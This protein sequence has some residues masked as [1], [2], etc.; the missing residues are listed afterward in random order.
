MYLLIRRHLVLAS[1]FGVISN[2]LVLTP[3]IYLL[4]VYD[5]V[6]PSRSIETLLMLMAFMA[7][8]L[9]MMLLV[10]VVR[11]RILADLGLQLCARLDRLALLARLDASAR[12]R[13]SSTVATQTDI[14]TLRGFL[15][16]PGVVAF[17]DAPWLVIYLII[18]CLFHWV[19]CLIAAISGIVLFALALL[20]DRVI[21]KNIGT[22]TDKQRECDLAYSQIV[23]NAEV[24][25]VLGMAEKIVC[26]WDIRKREYIEAQ[27]QVADSS[28]FY[29][30][31]T[32]VSRQAI[33]VIM[34]A[35]GAWLVIN[36]HATP[37]VM[38]ATTILLGKALA[39]IEQMIGSWKQFGE[40]R[41]AWGRLNEL[42][43]PSSEHDTIALPAPAGALCIERVTF[44]VPS[45][46]PGQAGRLLLR[47]VQF[48]LGAGETLVI[49]G[50]SAS[51][52]STLL[53][54]IAGLWRPQVGAVRLDGADVSQWP[55][56]RL[57]QYLGYVPQDVELFAGTVAENIGRTARPLQLDSDSI[58]RAAKRAGAHEMI[59]GLPN[60]YDTQIGESGETLSGG[61]RQ[62]ISLARAL[63]G[64]PKLLLLD[65]PNANLDSDGEETLDAA[66]RQIR[67]DGVTVIAVT[68]RPALM[69]IADRVLMMRSGQV[70]R[71]GTRNEFA[72]KTSQ[73]T[74]DEIGVPP[75]PA[76]RS[77]S[78]A[79]AMSKA[80]DPAVR[81]LL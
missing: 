79:P 76:I 81:T 69:A 57:G 71:F 7:I 61:Q 12:Q 6:L 31:V 37:G 38:L 22:Y 43:K 63:Y 47:D 13:Q 62:R 74:A 32:K 4:Q 9:A 29:R 27:Q 52:K 35:A 25:T 67:A 1:G 8:T 73:N 56:D 80:L 78:I 33:Q 66:L 55:R 60:G 58:V 64:D 34:M 51:G 23:R 70:E 59:L 49:V 40:L 44:S 72:T 19:L 15:S 77:S 41:Q 54:V 21:A 28:A 30:N 2:L 53:R 14:N 39:P 68:H 10:D 75:T 42:L 65:E 48:S 18:I 26:A 3:T 45:R 17:L 46:V 16:G 5:R 11:G 24:V 50:P 36:E 20:N